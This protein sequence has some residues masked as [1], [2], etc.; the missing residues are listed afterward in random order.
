MVQAS[1]G[2]EVVEVVAGKMRNRSSKP[3]KPADPN[4]NSSETPA[5]SSPQSNVAAELNIPAVMDAAC[6]SWQHWRT[7]E[8]GKQFL[9]QFAADGTTVQYL[10]WKFVM[11]HF[12]GVLKV[13]VRAV[14]S[15]RWNQVLTLNPLALKAVMCMQRHT[16]STEALQIEFLPRTQDGREFWAS[17]RQLSR[18]CHSFQPFR[19]CRCDD[20]GEQTRE[21]CYLFSSISEFG[22]APPQG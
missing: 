3:A 16:R 10:N 17:V 2:H 19:R 15:D 12:A 13:N 1:L 6:G 4:V 11:N 18:F 20:F 5:S 8:K 7:P 21:S 9:H 22:D 14:D